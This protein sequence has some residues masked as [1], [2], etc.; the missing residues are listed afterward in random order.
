MEKSAKHL[1]VCAGGEGGSNHTMQFHS[2]WCCKPRFQSMS[3]SR[4]GKTP[5]TVTWMKQ[6]TAPSKYH[7]TCLRIMWGNPGLAWLERVSDLVSPWTL[8][9]PASAC[10]CCRWN[11]RC[12]VS[13]P[14]SL[15]TCVRGQDH[16]SVCHWSQYLGGRGGWISMNS[17]TA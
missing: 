1:C 3:W 9:L 15:P 16:E 10:C 17:R 4:A 11:Y 8:N 7:I 5:S 13:M 14:V 12:V 6:S 2:G